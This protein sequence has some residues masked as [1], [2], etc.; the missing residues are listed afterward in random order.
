MG[1]LPA[2]RVGNRRR[3]LGGARAGDLWGGETAVRVGNHEVSH[4]EVLL[5]SLTNKRLQ[6]VF[7][8]SS[9]ERTILRN[10]GKL[11]QG[12]A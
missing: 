2:C 10:N 9:N 1:E 8:N 12:P 4:P 6:F 5:P 7:R 11:N 3:W